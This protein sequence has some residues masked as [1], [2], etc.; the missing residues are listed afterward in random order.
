MNVKLEEPK[1]LRLGPMKKDWIGKEPD[2]ECKEC[3]GQ[4]SP[5]CGIHP[6]GC[7][8]GGFTDETAYWMIADECDLY[9]GEEAN[10]K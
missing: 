5:K 8:Y 3:G 2:G 1:G 4:C 7:I 6:A 10:E 9:H